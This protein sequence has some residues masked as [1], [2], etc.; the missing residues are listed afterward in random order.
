MTAALCGCSEASSLSF[1]ED[2]YSVGV[3]KSLDLTLDLFP[4]GAAYEISVSND[5]IASVDGLTVT[6]IKSGIT[7]VTV[8]SGDKKD[9]ATLIV[10][11]A[12]PSDDN[13]ITARN[14]TV[15][16]YVTNYTLANLSADLVKSITYEEG[17]VV[18]YQLPYYYGYTAHG[19][20]TDES[21]TASFNISETV[22]NDFGLYCYLTENENSFTADENMLITGLT[23]PKLP[24][25]T[26][27]FP[28]TINGKT[29]KG[30]AKEAFTG[31]T[32]LVDANIPAC[33]ETIGDSAFAGCTALEKITFAE[34]SAL[35]EIGNLCF[36][37]T[38]TAEESDDTDE[39]SET[40]YT[41][42]DDSC[43]KFSSINLPD[44]VEKIGKFAFCYCT[45]LVIDKLPA[46]LTVINQG[47]FL[48][49]KISYLDLEN[50]TEIY[51]FAFKNCASLGEVVNTGN[52]VYCG[53]YAFSGTKLFNEQADKAG[54]VYAG[55]ML[56]GCYENYGK[57]TGGA[58]AEIAEGT[59]LI[60]NYAMCGSSQSELTVY[61]PS[62]EIII[63]DYAFR[64]DSDGV[65]LAVPQASLDDYAE[66]YYTYYNL[67]CYSET[68]SVDTE[69][70]YGTHTLLKFSDG[71]VF[72]DKYTCRK[73]K[74][75][76]AVIPEKLDLGQLGVTR[77]DRINSHAIDL[78]GGENLASLNL[79]NAGEIAYM[80]VSDCSALSAVYLTDSSKFTLCDSQ[81]IQFS[82]LKSGCVVYVRESD[83]ARYR[84]AYLSSAATFRSALRYECILTL[85]IINY[86]E[87]GLQTEYLATVVL[88]NNSDSSAIKTAP[89]GFTVTWYADSNK[90]TAVT[91]V[92]ESAVLYGYAVPK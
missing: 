90:T 47:A 28:E 83:Y 10:S 41:L 36:C 48:G 19:W 84:D 79:G 82:T 49:T 81:S 1:K 25:A 17:S 85:N 38:A 56:V 86:Q 8:K 29:V 71:R 54:L 59:T 6:G 89:Y 30:I 9:T 58:K 65:C 7:E 20:Y 67:F 23:Y 52:V 75:G 72:Y 53:G 70:N 22:S 76:K 3:G 68:V 60:A 32:I 21:C 69:I 55:T 39:D 87:A 40:E 2:T 34:G 13:Y 27:D 61:F 44:T 15:S 43:V 42:N 11:D 31:D 45:A 26:L 77:F 5:T 4:S 37:L 62:S 91:S 73:D 46:S 14:Y 78:D 35:K 80:A 74:D 12:E 64:T 33:Y 50:V 57:L 92:N 18:Y 24:H 16:F 63:G 88:P 51:A 66:K